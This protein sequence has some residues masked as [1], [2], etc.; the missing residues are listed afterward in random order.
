[1]LS[2]SLLQHAKAVAAGP[3]FSHEGKSPSPK[4]PEQMGFVDD[5]AA[6]PAEI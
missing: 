2:N 4:I 5:L 6:L 1:M 3:E